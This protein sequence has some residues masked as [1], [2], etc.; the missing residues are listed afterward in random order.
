MLLPNITYAIFVLIFLVRRSLQYTDVFYV[1]TGLAPG[2]EYLI[3]EKE[4]TRSEIHCASWCAM[5]AT[6][7]SAVFNS[8]KMH[9]GLY[10]ESQSASSSSSLEEQLI[11][12]R[13]VSRTTAVTV[14]SG[15]TD[16]T[17]VS[18]KTT[19]KQTT[20][21]ATEIDDTSATTDR[22]TS[23]ETKEATQRESSST[24]TGKTTATEAVTM[25][26]QQKNWTI[27]GADDCYLTTSMEYSGT[28]SHTVSGISCQYWNTDTPHLRQYLPLDTTAHDTNYCR[29]TN[30]YEGGPICYTS[31]PNVQWEYCYIVK[32]DACGVDER[33]PVVP[34][35]TT[36]QF[37][38]GKFIGMMFTCDKLTPGNSVDHCPVSQCGSDDQWTT[39]Y[40]VSCTDEDCYTDSTTYQGKVTCT[41]AGIPCKVWSSHG[42]Q[43]PS[44]SDKDT[45]YC[46]DPDNTGAPWCYTTD[47]DVTWDYC[48]VPKC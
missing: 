29:E 10:R 8:T 16:G 20:K 26:T 46:R 28:I 40:I 25:S 32:C 44:G 18:D 38:V 41:A 30:H 22:I 12:Q 13:D 11:L 35:G 1:V 24:I 3:T 34:I 7:M 42:G 48:P 15:T 9:C 47:P 36:S 31:D 27:L 23:K 2:N 4:K 43:A 37:R 39:G 6:C 19:T 17:Y 45:N 14:D 33:L 5:T 21:S